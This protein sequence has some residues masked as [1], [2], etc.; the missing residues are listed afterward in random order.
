M[1]G[2]FEDFE[3][4]KK[5]FTL[6][7]T[8]VF[9]SQESTSKKCPTDKSKIEVA[10]SVGS[11]ENANEKYERLQVADEGKCTKEI[12]KF[13][14]VLLSE[15]CKQSQFNDILAIT[16]FHFNLTFERVSKLVATALRDFF[17]FSF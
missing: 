7:S 1:S 16:D 15:T 12:V 2:S 6:T 13:S 11:P 9:G 10:V 3:N 14:P 5:P 17:K 4:L 8:I